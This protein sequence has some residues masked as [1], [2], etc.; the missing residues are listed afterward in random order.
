MK[1][2]HAMLTVVIRDQHEHFVQNGK[3]LAVFCNIVKCSPRE[4]GPII[5][6]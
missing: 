3:D 1:L 5:G 2:L 4:K 6:R